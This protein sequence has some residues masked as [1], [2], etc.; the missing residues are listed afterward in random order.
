MFCSVKQIKV[1]MA[2][3]RISLTSLNI[4]LHAPSGKPHQ[5]HAVPFWGPTSSSGV[6]KCGRSL[7]PRDQKR[8]VREHFL[9][10]IFHAYK[11]CMAKLMCV[12]LKIALRSQKILHPWSSYKIL[13]NLLFVISLIG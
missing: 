5:I 11:C 12:R 4:H 9:P 8:G 3:L 2:V 6:Q 1:T 10:F 13:T 7:A